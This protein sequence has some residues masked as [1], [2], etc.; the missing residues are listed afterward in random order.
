MADLEWYHKAGHL[1]GKLSDLKIEDFW[2]MKPLKD[3]TK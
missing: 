1:T 3:A 2:Y